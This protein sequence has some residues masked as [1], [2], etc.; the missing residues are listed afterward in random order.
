VIVIS[1]AIVRE[2][3]NPRSLHT[4]NDLI[5]AV[6]RRKDIEAV[7]IAIDDTVCIDTYCPILSFF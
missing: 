1:Q 2:A 3:E 4:G 5:L 6:S 7:S